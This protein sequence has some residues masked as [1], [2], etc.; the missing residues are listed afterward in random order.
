MPARLCPKRRCRVFAI[1]ATVAAMLLA[2]TWWASLH[3]EF[4]GL[5]EDI[6]GTTTTVRIGNGLVTVIRQP[7]TP[8][9]AR[10]VTFWEPRP[11][12]AIWSPGWLWAR[13]ATAGF[14]LPLWIP[15]AACALAAVTLW[16]IDTLHRRRSRA[17]LCPAC[18]YPRAGLPA[19]AACPE[20]GLAP[21]PAAAAS[22]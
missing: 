4:S 20:C 22:R 21:A 3:W 19:T 13:N 14:A 8:G 15:A 11:S 7:G 6:N 2:A 5:R 16:R 1:A 9:W 17:N 12:R 18:T 10:T